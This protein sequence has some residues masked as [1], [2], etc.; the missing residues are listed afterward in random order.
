ML[1]AASPPLRARNA[2]SRRRPCQQ[3][4]ALPALL[5]ALT[6]TMCASAIALG[7]L[8]PLRG[9]T[10]T[11]V[12]G[13]APPRLDRP[14]LGPRL[15]RALKSPYELAPLAVQPV[16]A[17]QPRS[18]EPAAGD[19]QV[20]RAPLNVMAD[21]TQN[22]MGKAGGTLQPAAAAAPPAVDAGGSGAQG[23]GLSASFQHFHTNW[24][25][26]AIRAGLGARH[27]RVTSAIPVA[28]GFPSALRR[29]IVLQAV[30]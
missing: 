7:S 20:G 3:L 6:N 9:P 2:D 1:G 12:G 10:R 14:A 21:A 13:R 23:R 15:C 8:R 22:S 16:S 30:C 29:S 26:A 18:A 19:Y 17:P 27:Q 5:Q 4:H 24:R 28:H 25:W 11:C